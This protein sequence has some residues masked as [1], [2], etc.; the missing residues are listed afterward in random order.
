MCGMGADFAF[1]ASCVATNTLTP[2]IVGAAASRSAREIMCVGRG[3]SHSQSDQLRS[4]SPLAAII[5][6]LSPALARNP[7]QSP[8]TSSASPGMLMT[9]LLLPIY[10]TA[11]AAVTASSITLDDNVRITAYSPRLV[12]VEP[13][14]AQFED[15]STFA[16]V[17]RESFAGAALKQ[18]DNATVASD[19]FVV[20]LRPRAP[21]PSC[22]TPAGDTDVSAA[23][24]AAKYPKSG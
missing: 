11:T 6:R 3:S 17:G 16:I 19:T 5:I 12:R 22:T 24:R 15:R 20:K 7:G 13:K 9:M 10:T 8:A 14:G 23:V 1:G 4:H 18:V 21:L 2:A